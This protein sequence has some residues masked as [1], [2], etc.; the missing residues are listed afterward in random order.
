M[1]EMKVRN[2]MKRKIIALMLCIVMLVGS[3]PALPLFAASNVPEIKNA[4]GSDYTSNTYIAAKL[5]ELFTML[6]YSSN[7]YFTVYGNRSCGNNWCS[8]CEGSNVAR[9]HPNL[10][11]KGV[12]DP[13][14][15]WSCFAFARYAFLYI[16]G[17]YADGLNYYGNVSSGDKIRRVGRVA[18]SGNG[19]VSGDYT[20][21]TL[22]NLQALLAQATPG[23]ILQGNGSAGSGNHTMIFLGCASDG[24]YVIHDN[25]FKTTSDSNGNAYGYNRVLISKLT[26]TS[27]MSNWGNVFSV[28]RAIE[29]YY[30]SAWSR[31][32]Q[33]TECKEHEYTS[34][35]G[36]Y[37]VNCGHQ[38]T[39]TLDTSAAGLYK[40]VT[41]ATIRTAPYF[42]ASNTKTEAQGVYL[43]AVGK[44]TNSIGETWYR[45]TNGLYT[46]GDNLTRAETPSGA[47]TFSLE[48]YPAGELSLGAAFNLMGKTTGGSSLTQVSG[49][50]IG[51]DGLLQH[52]T[53]YP[54]AK[55]LDMYSSTINYNLKFGTLAE[56]NYT[57][58]LSATDENGRTSLF[59]SSFRIVKGGGSNTPAAPS[60][61]TLSGRTAH[62]VTLKAVSGYEYK[63]EGG[64]WQR[65]NLFEGLSAVTEYSF[66][67]RLAASATAQA[68]P[69][70]KA[71]TVTTDKDRQTDTPKPT[72]AKYTDSSV[73]LNRISGYE[74]SM[75]EKHWQQDPFFDDLESSTAYLFYQR[76]AASDTYYAGEPSDAL[77][78]ITDKPTPAAPEEPVLLAFGDTSFEIETNE[79]L[80]YSI[81]K[82][83]WR[84]S[85]VFE[86]LAPG[87]VYQC[88]A[89]VKATE[90]AYAGRPSPATEITTDKSYPERPNAPVLLGKAGGSVSLKPVAGAEYSLDGQFW[91][92]SPDFKG[93]TV[94]R[95]YTF[96][97][98]Y[99]ETTHNYASETS[100]GLRVEI[101]PGSLSSGY[102]LVDNTSMT[103]R[104]VSAG[105]MLRTVIASLMESDYVRVYSA[106]GE[107]L[108]GGEVAAT[109]MELVIC[110]GEVRE[111]AYGIA[112]RGDL[113]G[114]GYLTVNDLAELTEAVEKREAGELTGLSRL[115]WY[116]ADLNG[117]DELNRLDLAMLRGL[118]LNAAD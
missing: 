26:Y 9:Q 52:S 3:L 1:V 80:E 37:C 112:V 70:S 28:L 50:L 103:V 15:C 22:A 58:L 84:S 101:L 68:S 56:G 18:R 4:K 83:H 21:Y 57:F 86:G 77:T 41:T 60:A 102:M 63:I 53:A 118:L 75:D 108:G 88:Y 115:R 93:L 85:G 98:R 61:P 17:I 81:D 8:S 40:T 91:Q 23:D 48:A 76:M 33:T 20:S 5:D 31:S 105:T 96:Y 47:P 117:D 114:D 99:A 25:M 72:L 10:R 45:L 27:I 65:S 32:G 51:S 16:F 94:S 111:I 106:D 82:I 35:G 19:N 90:F 110:D 100:D 78:V 107:Q 46:H 11:Q 38:Y 54:S 62:S 104:N 97:Q 113:D 116:A 109:G 59:T 6:P 7:P 79:L 43:A 44:L 73:T 12:Y 14:T 55:T 67:Q 66:Y 49:C 74:Y 69:S 24:V 39:T 36:D 13:H 42:S 64:S 30:S 92:S 2:G 34:Q 29:P 87:T 95:V 89:R 71:L